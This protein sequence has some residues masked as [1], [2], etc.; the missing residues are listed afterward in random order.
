[1]KAEHLT[2]EEYAEL[3]SLEYVVT[4]GYASDSEIARHFYLCK[5]NQGAFRTKVISAFPGTGKSHFYNSEYPP[6]GH[7]IMMDS[8]SSKFDKSNFPSNYIR[9]IVSELGKQQYI[10]ASSHN[11]VR[12]ELVKNQIPFLLVYPN[13][14]LKYEY[15]TRY[16]ERGSPNSFIELI[17]NNWNNFIDDMQNQKGCIHIVLQSG[18]FISDLKNIVL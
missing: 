3:V 6:D 8:D 11:E 10:F 12:Q 4:Q 5:I 1:M 18:Q 2:Q 7:P 9:H 15:I 17:D 13:V 16:V 14:S